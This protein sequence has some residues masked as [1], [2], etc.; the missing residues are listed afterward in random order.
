M[1]TEHVGNLQAANSLDQLKQVLEQILG[2]CESALTHNGTLDING[3]LRAGSTGAVV[4]IS[5]GYIAPNDGT[6]EPDDNGNLPNGWALAVDGGAWFKGQVKFDQGGG[7]ANFEQLLA[8]FPV[9]FQMPWHDESDIPT[10][11][12]IMDGVSNASGSGINRGGRVGYGYIAGDPTF[13]TLGTA[14]AISLASSIAG[15]GSSVNTGLQG[16]HSHTTSGTNIAGAITIS[17]HSGSGTANT[18][19][20]TAAITPSALLEHFDVGS[21]VSFYYFDAAPSVL[22]HTHTIGG[23]D[24]AGLLGNHTVS[25]GGSGSA[26]SDTV[27]DH[28]HTVAVSAIA[29]GLSIGTPSTVRP[30]GVVEL[31]IEKLS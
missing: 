11:W 24:V 6:T 5:N 15:D 17:A 12:A 4:N 16:S 14:V 13:G 21:A 3:A 1:F 19:S 30:P 25:S 10:G 29:A 22:G 7:I 8:L 27:S 28:A 26:S 2:D 23:S 18:G 20:S 31:W 9:G